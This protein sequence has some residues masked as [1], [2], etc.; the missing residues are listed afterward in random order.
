MTL[1]EAIKEL[2][3]AFSEA[4]GR[5]ICIKM[6]R[7]CHRSEPLQS[8]CYCV[9]VQELLKALLMRELLKRILLK[10][11][12]VKKRYTNDKDD[13]DGMYSL[14]IS[15]VSGE[16][17]E[18]VKTALLAFGKCLSEFSD[19]E[20]DKLLDDWVV[21]CQEDTTLSEDNCK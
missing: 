5:P 9:P 3:K 12:E 1:Q 15:G 6:K 14:C 13:T 2:E 11:P 16:A 19:G 17:I 4:C 20:L 18:G 21:R 8:P 7:E 10:N